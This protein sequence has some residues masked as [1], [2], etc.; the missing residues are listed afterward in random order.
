MGDSTLRCP[1]CGSE[2]IAV[3]NCRCMCW[4]CGHR[5]EAPTRAA[6]LGKAETPL[7]IFLSYGHTE[8]KIVSR[9]REHLEARGHEVWFDASEIKAGDDWRASIAEGVSSSNGVIA[10][11]SKHAFREGG[12]C[13]D[14]IDIA[15]GIRGGNIKTVLLDPEGEVRPPSVLTH[16]QW[17]D[18]AIWR[19]KLAEGP[20]VFEPW[21]ERCMAELVRV[22]ES[23]ESV[24]FSGDITEISR[25]LVVLADGSRQAD[26][27]AKP[28]Q[29]R[30]W[31]T[32]QVD[33]WLADRESPRVCLITGDPGVG[34][35]AFAAHLSHWDS[36]LTGRIAASVFCVRGRTA[37]NDAKTVIQTLAYLLAC[38]IPQ[39][40]VLLRQTLD[41]GADLGA[42]DEGSLFS[43]LIGEPFSHAIDGGHE[44]MA[45]VIDGIDE[46]GSA[47]ENALAEV[48]GSYAES[49]PAWMK[50]LVTSRR[51]SAAI[52]PF[53][54][55]AYR[56][57]IEG[58]SSKNMAD[59]RAHLAAKLGPRFGEEPGF[60]SIVDAIAQSSGGAF[61]Y[62]EYMTDAL[63]KGRA[64]LA[65]VVREIPEGLGGMFRQWFRWT[66]PDL[67]EYRER[68]RDALGSILAAPGGALPTAELSVLFGWD[69]NERNDF[70]R[71]IEVFLVHSVDAFGNPSVSFNHAFVVQWLGSREAGA[72]QCDPAAARDLMVKRWYALAKRNP[73]KLP[74]YEAVNIFGILEDA[75]M[76]A[77]ADQLW[78][79]ERAV[80]ALLLILDD[81]KAKG[82]YGSVLAIS[83][84]LMSLLE[85]QA[86]SRME[87]RASM[88]GA[89]GIAYSDMNRFKDAV[90]CY[91]EAIAI[92]RSLAKDRPNAYRSRIA[93]LL[94]NL[95]IVLEASGDLS[96]ARDAYREGLSILRQLDEAYPAR[97]QSS[98]ANLLSDYSGVLRMSHRLAEAE[99]TIREAISIRRRLMESGS[100][101]E[102]R[103]VIQSLNNLGNI[104]NDL[105][106]FTE[107]EE[108]FREAISIWNSIPAEQNNF[109]NDIALVYSNLGSTLAALGRFEEAADAHRLALK[110]RQLLAE[111]EASAFLPDVAASLVNLGASLGDA[112]HYQEAIEY[113]QEGISIFE[114]LSDG[115]SE[116]YLPSVAIARSALGSSLN[117][118]GRNREAEENLRE[119]LS[120]RTALS[121]KEPEAYRESVVASILGL[122]GIVADTGRPEEE[123][124]LQEQGLSI[125]ERMQ[126]SSPEAALPSKAALLNNRGNTLSRLGRFDEALEAHREAVAIRRE[127]AEKEPGAYR[128]MLAKSLVN[129]GDAL[130]SLSRYEEAAEA[131]REAVGIYRENDQL[132]NNYPAVFMPALAAANLT[133]GDALRLC[134]S[135]SEAES[136]YR[137]A[138]T[139]LRELTEKDDSKRYASYLADSLFYLALIF[140]V[141]A[142]KEES[143]PY[144]REA[145]TIWKDLAEDDAAT[146]APKLGNAL[147]LLGGA[148]SDAGRSK[149]AAEAHH[150]SVALWR[151]LV[152]EDET[153]HLRDLSEALLYL[154]ND[155]SSSG[156]KDGAERAFGE[157]VAIGRRLVEDDSE[158]HRALFATQLMRHGAMLT[159]SGRLREAEH[160]LREAFS[161]WQKL[162]MEGSDPD[163]YAPD[164]AGTL[165]NLAFL[166]SKLGDKGAAARVYL[167]A[168]GVYRTLV[169]RGKVKHR[170]DLEAVLENYG[171]V[172]KELGNA[173]AARAAQDAVSA[174]RGVKSVEEARAAMDHVD[175]FIKEQEEAR[176]S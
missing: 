42:I 44:C 154:G 85:K 25:R 16:I 115:E 116:A 168:A 86:S 82:C 3:R 99:N 27:L 138:I 141:T 35:S 26:L 117:G 160:E 147:N 76:H 53:E 114:K 94:D 136:A 150:E 58:S 171:I 149:E 59:V 4:D 87:Q 5:F 50:V 12:V 36:K 128:I 121:E 89:L 155:L 174:L 120:I 33:A 51:A 56:I 70:L 71:R 22:V 47:E 137:E 140:C 112:G 162:I 11:L 15:V 122:S 73:A 80:D 104:L 109:L 142:R 61:L 148:L 111:K 78:G 29:G 28:F 68:F 54:G 176:N 126:E 46:A 79:D 161:I 83:R 7:R 1:A 165:W 133:L 17:L 102:C 119:S 157:A 146:Y 139:M 77:E 40:R 167:Q 135:Y 45:I 144:Y 175:A 20:E 127:L 38:R 100:A 10:C 24:Q 52:G 103:D 69:A 110:V 30:A 159:S 163:R 55:G 131:L 96:G 132:L 32:E 39:Y 72:Y 153:M 9:I 66:F 6:D 60:S 156:D 169:R 98:L 57:D 88:L 101:S 81:L 92:R 31:L 134:R 74:D 8:E 90:A 65:D 21:F 166:A 151:R 173:D 14:E 172:L 164:G 48:I 97:Y 62:A 130:N 18:M 123:L 41:K 84:Q 143:E 170:A 93:S 106:R 124:A 118:L 23:K 49:L 105:D 64:S 75:G 129:L 152:E 95:G 125:I 43:L 34:K 108:V 19:E 107:A 2:D 113:L 37:Y 63:L 145:I 67:A 158:K 13:H 91:Q